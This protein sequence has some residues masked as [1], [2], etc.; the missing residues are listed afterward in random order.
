M[1]CDV[2]K[3][4]VWIYLEHLSVSV[5]LAGPSWQVFKCISKDLDGPTPSFQSSNSSNERRNGAE[6]NFRC[7]TCPLH[8]QTRTLLHGCRHGKLLK[9]LNWG[10]STVSTSFEATGNFLG[11]HASLLA[12]DPTFLEALPE[13][14]WAGVLASQQALAQPP[15]YTAPT[16]EDIDPEFLAALP[17]DIQAEVLAQQR[18]QRVVQ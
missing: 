17:L 13:D 14:L 1:V 3:V 9:V 8:R 15:S 2:L 4:L 11:Y 6:G 18:A 16:A 5:H 10:F 7:Q 12:I